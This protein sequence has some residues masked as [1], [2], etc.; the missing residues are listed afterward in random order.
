MSSLLMFAFADQEMAMR[1]VPSSNMTLQIY[2]IIF[3]NAISISWIIYLLK[4]I[5]VGLKA[6]VQGL[7]T[8]SNNHRMMFT[9]MGEQ[10]EEAK[11]TNSMNTILLEN[12]ARTTTNLALIIKEAKETN[13]ILSKLVVKKKPNPTDD[14]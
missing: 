4:D 10:L 8:V 6:T 11:K 2:F 12:S 7:E 14:H 9:R 5:R 13:E 3:C 1:V